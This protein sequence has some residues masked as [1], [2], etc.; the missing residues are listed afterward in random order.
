MTETSKLHAA[1]NIRN[2]AFVGHAGAGKTTLIE[3]LLAKAGAIR[4]PGRI[5]KGNTTS[6]FTEHEKRLQHS[7]DVGICHLE[8][9]G[10]VVNLLDTPGY[11]DFLGRALAVLPAVETAAVVIN[12][13]H[14]VE[15]VTQRAMEAAA[16]DKL[17]RLVIVNKIDLPRHGS[18][19][20]ARGD[21]R[22]L[23]QGMPAAEPA[24]ARRAGRRR[25]LLRAGR[26]DARFLRR[27]GRAYG[28]HRPSRRARR[29][30]HGALPRAGR[31]HHARA[32]PRSV[33]ACAPA[34]PSRSGLLHFGRD[35]RGAA[36]AAARVLPAH[37]EPLR[38]QSR[39]D[40]ERRRRRAGVSRS[41]PTSTTAISSDMSSKSRS[42][43]YVGRLAALRVH[44]GDPQD[45]RSSL[46]RRETQS[47]SSSRICIASKARRRA[48]S[49]SASAGDFCAVAKID[50]VEFNDVL[51]ASHD[52]DALRMPRPDIPAAD[53]RRCG[54]ACAAR[55]GEEA[56]RGAAQARSRGPEPEHRVQRP[57]QRNRAT[58]HGRAAR[59]AW[60]SSA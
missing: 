52:E 38:G 13:Q 33:R 60:C 5:D 11:P 30:A 31:E 43:P 29:R 22:R 24:G 12:A 54:R 20:P 36:S 51:H 40:S 48:R 57:S 55:S 37:A 26:R 15:L 1:R 14:G 9:D 28:D 2:I 44:Q 56:L 8:H 27:C 4:T 50:N 18:R 10:K 32:A 39:R 6:D 49:A 23:R 35:G 3:Q 21:P 53:V 16:R 41:T 42:I 59:C 7:L 46:R 45:R 19:R 34:R 25:L 58:R 17:C 47:A